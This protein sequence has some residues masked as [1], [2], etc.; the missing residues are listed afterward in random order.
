[1]ERSP[2]NT[3]PRRSFQM[4]QTP[5]SFKPQNQQFTPWSTSLLDYTLDE[6]I[7]AQSDVTSFPHLD[8]DDLVGFNDLAIAGAVIHPDEMWKVLPEGLD[9]WYRRW[10]EVNVEPSEAPRDPAKAK[11]ARRMVQE[12]EDWSDHDDLE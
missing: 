4:I 10:V 12:L 9:A 7:L 3:N 11:R 6:P 1:M 8:D 5:L 2:L